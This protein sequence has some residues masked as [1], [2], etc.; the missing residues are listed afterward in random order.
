VSRGLRGW[1]AAAGV[2]AVAALGLPWS[3]A[4]TADGSPAVLLG[5]ASPARV[6]LVLLGLRPGRERLLPFAV[7][8]GAVGVVV[9]G[10]APTPGRVALAAAVG[11]LVTGLRA[12]GRRHSRGER[13]ALSDPR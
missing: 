1:L 12:D 4:G 6:V 9:G 10:P 2:C 5:T 3:M 8:A 7:L 13:P 11:C